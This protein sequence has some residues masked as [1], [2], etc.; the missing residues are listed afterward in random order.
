MDAYRTELP[1]PIPGRILRLPIARGYPV[2]A[3]VAWLDRDGQPVERGEG[4]PDFRVV[5]PGGIAWA[6]NNQRCWI[7]GDPLGSFKTFTIGSMCA[8][9]RTS[10]EPPSHLECSDWSARACP[11]LSR[12]H[13][14]RREAGLPDK[15]VDA[16]GIMLS[17]NPGVALVW[18]TRSYKPISDGM[19]GVLFR[20]GDPTD[21]RWYA[22][23]RSATRE[24]VMA[25]INS[26]LPSLRELA[27]QERGGIAALERQTAEALELIP[28]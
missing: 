20:I 25:S 22:E 28:A 12:P 7:C 13:A 1:T 5:R 26:G 11:F 10:A 21:V 4:T 24:E 14:H 6:H 15:R 19:G 16:P 27:E 18:T 3:F 8:V 9:N 23:G 17:R 2:P